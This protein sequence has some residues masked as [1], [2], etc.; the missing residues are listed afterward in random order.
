MGVSP[1]LAA[2]TV[3]VDRGFIVL[4]ALWG[5]AAVWAAAWRSSDHEPV[6]MNWF[7]DIVSAW[8]FSVW[9]RAFW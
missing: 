5:V 9:A 4:L 6:R 7:A 8:A 2:L 1:T 3:Y